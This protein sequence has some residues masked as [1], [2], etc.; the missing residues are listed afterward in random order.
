[1]PT[2]KWS[3]EGTFRDFENGTEVE[4]GETVELRKAVAD[5]WDDLERVAPDE[6]AAES[7][8]ITCAEGDCSRTVDEDG[9]YCWQHDSDE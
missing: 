2:Y 5:G 4:P 7:D 1:M 6:S 8:E 9:A 3:G